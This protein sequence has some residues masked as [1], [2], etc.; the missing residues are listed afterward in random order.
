MAYWGCSPL[1]RYVLTS[2]YVLDSG[3]G[4]RGF[5]NRTVLNSTV[6]SAIWGPTAI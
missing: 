1:R 4:G 3:S 5:L 6:V 2:F